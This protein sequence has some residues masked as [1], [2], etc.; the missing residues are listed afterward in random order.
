MQKALSVILVIAVLG[1]LGI[2]FYVLTQPEAGERFTEFYILGPEGKAAYYPTELVVGG[3]GSMIVGIANH[4]YETVSYRVVVNI[5]GVKKNEMEP[6]VLGHE[7]QW[8]KEVSF[9]PKMAGEQKVEF[10]LYKNGEAEPY[11][12][13]LYLWVEVTD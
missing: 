10:L 4:E 11:L 2:L 8:E 3:E 1:V 5:G 13:P 7:E 6:V 12:K 9:T